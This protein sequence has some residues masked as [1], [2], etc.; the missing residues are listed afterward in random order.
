MR[1]DAEGSTDSE[2]EAVEALVTPVHPQSVMP[3]YD[4]YVAEDYATPTATQGIQ[5]P[6]RLHSSV[7]SYC[8]FSCPRVNLIPH[9][10]AGARGGLM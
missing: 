9:A 2:M 7:S 4:A 3:F 1:Q 10:V 6:V 8:A 5:E